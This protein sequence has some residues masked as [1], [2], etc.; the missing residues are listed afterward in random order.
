MAPKL[1][2]KFDDISKTASSVLG[3]DYQCKD[4]ALKTKNKSNFANATAELAVDLKMADECKTPAKATFKFPKPIPFLDGLAIDKLD[5]TKEGKVQLEC[6][7][8]KALHKV[9]GLKL[10]VKTDLKE[11]ITYASTFTGVKDLTLKL[12]TKHFSPTDFTAE[13]LYGVGSCVIG[14][15][16]AGLKSLIPS[17]GVNFQSGDMFASIIVKNELQVFSGHGFYKVSDDI[18]LAASYQQGGKDSGNFAVGAAATINKET[19]A[20]AKFESTKGQGKV[21]VAF[22]RDLAKGTCCGL[23]GTTVLGGVSYDV[24][25]GGFGY[26]AKLNIE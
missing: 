18:K 22:K 16:Q 15:K 26:G 25:S 3:D 12:D 21:S 13:A 20:R 2:G 5:L 24:S 6:S 7:L 1:P 4:F 14:I 9:D 19:T 8:G 10:E 23:A 11:Q 17:V